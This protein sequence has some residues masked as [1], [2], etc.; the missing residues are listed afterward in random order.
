MYPYMLGIP[1]HFKHLENPRLRN[2]G[3]KCI[4]FGVK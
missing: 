4:E 3:Y 2:N 1:E